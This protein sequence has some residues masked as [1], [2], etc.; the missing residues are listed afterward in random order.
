MIRFRRQRGEPLV[1]RLTTPF[2][3]ADIEIAS[4][5][6]NDLGG[7]WHLAATVL[8]VDAGLFELDAGVDARVL[9]AGRL[10]FDIRFRRFGENVHT[11]TFRLDL[12]DDI[13]AENTALTDRAQYNARAQSD[14]RVYLTREGDMLDAICQTELGADALAPQLLDAHPRLAELGPVYPAGLALFLPTRDRLV[15]PRTRRITLWGRA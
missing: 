2:A 13:A 10:W 4:S 7:A 11:L 8:D 14:G 5:L 6:R 12:L 15:A 3:L 9:P 1:L